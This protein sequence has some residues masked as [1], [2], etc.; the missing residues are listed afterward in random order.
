MELLLYWPVPKGRETKDFLVRVDFKPTGAETRQDL[1]KLGS[2]RHQLIQQD[3]T[4]PRLT[5]KRFVRKHDKKA[6]TALIGTD[7]KNN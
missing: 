5:P 7:F 2:R 6:S 1:E 3:G 4:P